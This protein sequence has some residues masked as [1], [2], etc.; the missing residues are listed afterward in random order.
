MTLYGYARVSTNGQILAA[1]DAALHAPGCAKVYRE[2]I[3]GARSDRPQLAKLLG[4]LGEGD[5]V[6]VTRLDRLARST[7][8]CSTC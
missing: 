8:A 4:L 5:T 2:K 7:R 1:Q 6:V 3:S